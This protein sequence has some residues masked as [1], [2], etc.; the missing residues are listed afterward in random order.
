MDFSFCSLWFEEEKQESV[1]NYSKQT[2]LLTSF[3]KQLFNSL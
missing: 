1:Q 3:A 2:F